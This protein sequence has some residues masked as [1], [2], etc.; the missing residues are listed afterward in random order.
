[1]LVVC[2]LSEKRLRAVKVRASVSWS[3]NS[4]V[5]EEPKQ[6]ELQDRVV[7]CKQTSCVLYS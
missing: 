4:S 5:I 6:S 2:E 7:V 3:A 1:M